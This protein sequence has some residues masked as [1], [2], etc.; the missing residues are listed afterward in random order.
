MSLLCFDS[1]K[2]MLAEDKKEFACYVATISSTNKYYWYAKLPIGSSMDMW[3]N[4]VRQGLYKPA[5]KKED[6]YHIVST[7]Q[8]YKD[9]FRFRVLTE[10]IAQDYY[11]APT[12]TGYRDK[13]L[14][15]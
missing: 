12:R 10:E 11:T 9:G 3:I 1:K 5:T 7:D 14:D 6:L 13:S 15:L 8:A 4:D 2:M